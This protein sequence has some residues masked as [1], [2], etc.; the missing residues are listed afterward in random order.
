MNFPP[1]IEKLIKKFAQPHWG[2]RANWREGSYAA[3]A[4]NECRWWD[5]YQLFRTEF[6]DEPLPGL[7]KQAAKRERV[8][9]VEWCKDKLII[10]PPRF[11]GD[12]EIMDFD[13]DYLTSEERGYLF[14]CD[15]FPSHDDRKWVRNRFPR[16]VPDWAKDEW[17]NRPG[18][19]TA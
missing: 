16:G 8:T 13:E 5:D 9:W 17:C 6:G 2:L 18:S 7:R 14:W 15:N 12:H 4:I 1:E 11:R 3:K 10:G 19:M